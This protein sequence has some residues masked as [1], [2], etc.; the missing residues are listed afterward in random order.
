MY[1]QIYDIICQYVY[2]SPEALTAY[3]EFAATQAATFMCFFCLF[4]PFVAIFIA[5]RWFFK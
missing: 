1:S 4:I 2:G 3:Q 5:F